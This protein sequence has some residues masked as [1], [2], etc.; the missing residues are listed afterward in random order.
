MRKK[1]TV[2]LSALTMA[3][4]LTACGNSADSGNATPTD[5][6]L[7]TT[8]APESNAPNDTDATVATDTPAPTAALLPTPTPGP[9]ATPRPDISGVSLKE[10]YKDYFMIG[11]IYTETI[12]S[13]ADNALIKQHFNVMTPENLM[14]PE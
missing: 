14:K 5:S 10:L 11:T 13:G 7:R 6:V 2:L 8:V 1:L 9:T 3:T 12:D 4:L